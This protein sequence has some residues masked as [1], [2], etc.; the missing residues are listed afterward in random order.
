MV[1]TT[2]R[3]FNRAIA[4]A[5]TRKGWLK[6]DMIIEDQSS[7]CPNCKTSLTWKSHV[8]RWELGREAHEFTFSC[9]SCKREYQFKDDRIIEKRP[10]K[11]PL[12]EALAIQHSQLYDAINRRCLNCGG[13]ITNGGLALRCEWCHQEYSAIDGYLQPKIIDQPQPRPSMREFYALHR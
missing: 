2:I 7:K 5:S 1:R 13:P 9:E 11:D 12:A 6:Q 8:K 10:D 4:T 3:W